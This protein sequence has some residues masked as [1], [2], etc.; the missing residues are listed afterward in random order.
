MS[1]IIAL[2]YAR[3]TSLSIVNLRREMANINKG[4]DRIVKFDFN[5]V[6]LMKI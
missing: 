4:E 1:F 6:Q 5:P 3:L 2:L